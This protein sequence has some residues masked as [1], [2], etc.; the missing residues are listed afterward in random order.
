MSYGC[1]FFSTFVQ[2]ITGRLVDIKTIPEPILM[3]T[4][5]FNKKFFIFPWTLIW[6]CYCT[7]SGSSENE[8]IVTR[9]RHIASKLLVSIGRGIRLPPN[10]HHAITWTYANIFSTGPSVIRF[11]EIWWKFPYKNIYEN[12]ICMC[13]AVFVQWS[14]ADADRKMG[15]I[16][17]W[18]YWYK[19]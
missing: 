10:R 5:T 11:Y 2:V 7:T 13:A 18:N 8:L 12:V 15:W 17:E 16:H 14:C 4:F 19:R 9:W 3:H 6:Y 1:K